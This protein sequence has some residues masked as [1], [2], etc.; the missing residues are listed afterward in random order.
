MGSRRK[1]T[2]VVAVRSTS[3]P[4]T[5]V[6]KELGHVDAPGTDSVTMTLLRRDRP[7]PLPLPSASA[8]N[9][10]HFLPPLRA[11]LQPRSQP[12]CAEERRWIRLRT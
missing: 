12:R 8:P 3:R 5:C 11:R 10:L 9:L 7:A 2:E 6:R 1:S 4:L